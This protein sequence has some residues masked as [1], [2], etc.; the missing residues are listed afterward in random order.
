MKEHK[1]LEPKILDLKNRLNAKGF[2]VPT[3]VRTIEQLATY[4]SKEIR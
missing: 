3:N 4:L 1:L 2:N